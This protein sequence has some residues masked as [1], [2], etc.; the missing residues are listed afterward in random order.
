MEETVF[1]YANG[2]KIYQ[3]KAKDSENTPYPLSVSTISK[4]FTMRIMEKL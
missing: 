1:L 2:V 3:F 4:D